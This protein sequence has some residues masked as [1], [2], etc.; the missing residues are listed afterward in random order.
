MALSRPD[1]SDRRNLAKVV[2]ENAGV[3][4]AITHYV[5]CVECVEAESHGVLF[6]NAKVLERRHI[7]IEVAWPADGT[8]ARCTKGVGSGHTKC[9]DAVVHARCG[10][11][12][13]RRIVAIPAALEP[14]GHYFAQRTVDDPEF[15]ILVDSRVAV[16]VG[17]V[18]GTGDGFRKT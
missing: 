8:I 4:I 6:R 10:T 14:V 17:G 7:H 11:G 18:S 3:W 16:A 9:A 15:A 12:R 13:R 5:K 1:L 2:I